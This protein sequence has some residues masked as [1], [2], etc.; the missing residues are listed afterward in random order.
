MTM[1]ASKGLE[2]DNVFIPDVNENVIPNSKAVTECEIEEE[3]RML[4]VAMT[5]AKKRLYILYSNSIRSYSHI[6]LEKI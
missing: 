2:F 4:Y 1:H 3:R 6:R 5:R